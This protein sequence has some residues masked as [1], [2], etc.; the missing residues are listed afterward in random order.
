MSSSSSSSAATASAAAAAATVASSSSSAA[1]AAQPQ[2]LPPGHPALLLAPLPGAGVTPQLTI[3]TIPRDWQALIISYL[4]W[5]SHFVLSRVNTNLRAACRARMSWGGDRRVVS[6]DVGE[7]E[8]RERLV[9]VC[10]ALRSDVFGLRTVPVALCLGFPGFAGS[11]CCQD[12]WLTELSSL[13]T[14]RYLSLASCRDV[15]DAGL[16]HVSALTQLQ[17]LNLRLCFRITDAGLS[18]L[19]S[20]TQLQQLLSQPHRRRCRPSVDADS[21]AAFGICLLQPHHRRRPGARVDAETAF[22]SQSDGL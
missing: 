9:R 11:G 1:A 8:S 21:V 17:R 3:E 5:R 6:V 15:T 12:D 16:A 20:L 19:A 13:P 18:Q 7:F 22:T 4:D 14:L 10:A 2:P